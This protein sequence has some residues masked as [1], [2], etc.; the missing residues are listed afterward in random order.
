MH[1]F[2]TVLNL[3]NDLIYVPSK[4]VI[5][6]I[7]EESQNSEYAAGQ[8]TLA[9]DLAI[10]TVLFR[11]ARITPSKVG[12]F[13]TFWEK[14]RSGT[15][16]PYLYSEAP[17]LLIITVCKD[18]SFNDKGSKADNFKNNISK[19]DSIFGQFI[20]PKNVLLKKNILKSDITKGKMGIRVYPSWDTPTNKTAVK[21]QQWQLD[22]FFAVENL[23][24]LPIE[25]ILKLYYQ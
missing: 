14:S 3:V 19:N 6:D 25:R 11:A 22:Y 15:N 5:T 2:K 13:V 1:S 20:F 4:L 18:K 7:K 21:T 10:K 17:D 24:V 12:Q 16:Q 23:N 9:S 8:F